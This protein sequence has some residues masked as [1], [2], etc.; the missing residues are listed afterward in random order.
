MTEPD[1]T[2]KSLA[3]TVT[4][5]DLVK[6]TL[7]LHDII[8]KFPGMTDREIMRDFFNDPLITDTLH[9][10]AS[11]LQKFVSKVAKMHQT[12][13]K[14]L[15]NPFRRLVMGTWREEH[16]WIMRVV[17]RKRN[18]LSS[19]QLFSLKNSRRTC[20][21]NNLRRKREAGLVLRGE[22]RKQPRW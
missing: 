7:H 21:N 10:T 19:L 3:N 16:C 1:T 8:S 5:C 13:D 2:K 6:R 17:T 22:R 9:K 15:V 12:F 18:K 20:S 14:Q 11:D 4:Q